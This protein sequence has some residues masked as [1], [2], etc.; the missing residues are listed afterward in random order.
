MEWYQT[1]KSASGSGGLQSVKDLTL[2]IINNFFGVLFL[3]NDSVA[4]DYFVTNTFG[5]SNPERSK[6]SFRGIIKAAKL[7]VY[8]ER[9]TTAN[10]AHMLFMNLKIE[11]RNL[12]IV[13]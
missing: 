11:N 6:Y 12:K 8:N 9:K 7:A 13:G 1:S 2:E 4:I 10:K 3:K 5:S